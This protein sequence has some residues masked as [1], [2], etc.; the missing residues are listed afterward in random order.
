MVARNENKEILKM[1]SCCIEIAIFKKI[2]AKNWIANQK[3]I[4]FIY[5]FKVL[6]NKKKFFKENVTCKKQ[7]KTKHNKK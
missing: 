7:N 6:F 5:L 3:K 2:W 4:I 1:F